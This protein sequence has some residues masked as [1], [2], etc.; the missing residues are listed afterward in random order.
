MTLQEFLGRVSARELELWMRYEQMSGPI[1]AIRSDL[2]TGI[3]ASTLANCHIK[4]DSKLFTP[5]DFMP[6][7]DA[8]K[9]RKRKNRGEMMLALARALGFKPKAESE[10]DASDQGES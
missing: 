9:K 8:T 4:K 7:F 5:R 10:S 6:D 1:G 3:I 2:H